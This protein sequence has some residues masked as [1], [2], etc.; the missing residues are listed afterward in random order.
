MKKY[1]FN[2][3]TAQQGP[4]DLEELK[5]KN[6]T[7]ET[8]VWYEGLPEWTT[9]GK[10]EELNEMFSPVLPSLTEEVPSAIVEES[11]PV[12]TVSTEQVVETATTVTTATAT[13][14]IPT[15]V[16]TAKKS[17]AWLSWALSLLVLG[18]AGYFVYQDMEK[19]R[20]PSSS[21][22]TT[23]LT[24][25]TLG[26]IPMSETQSSTTDT[27]TSP[28]AT[29]ATDTTTTI[30]TTEPVT[31][32][33]TTTTVATTTTAQ[34]TA[35]KNAATK[36]AEEEKKKKQLA[37][38]A[39]KKAE[40]EKKKLEAAKAAAAARE[41]DMRNRW[42]KYITIG[43][44]N[45]ETKGDGIKSFDVPVYNGTDAP[46]DKVTVRIEYTK[47]NDRKIVK[48]ETITVYNIPARGGVNGKAPESKKGD[49]VN[50]FITGINSKK[51]HF[52]YPQ[53]NGNPTDPFFC[54]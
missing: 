17:T 31:L 27:S 5:S 21:N 41:M 54:N 24:T 15:K 32:P 38:L 45:Y 20:T 11:V 18:G 37:L 43:N 8:P 51:L 47:K 48:T 49:K 23:T 22:A 9:A 14:A 34:Q 16:A 2:D 53:G 46:L 29:I 39:Q 4:F 6:I 12:T 10:L 25:D 40:E 36:K 30:T 19:N 44:L 52:C 42:S 1:F 3:G 50:V 35:T 26:T 28:V 7:A 33:P 13:S